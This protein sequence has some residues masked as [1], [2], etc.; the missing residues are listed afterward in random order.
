[1]GYR[2][3]LPSFAVVQIYGDN[4]VAGIANQHAGRVIFETPPPYFSTELKRERI[5]RDR[6]LR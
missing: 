3:P 5:Y 2:E 4:D 1:M 6:N